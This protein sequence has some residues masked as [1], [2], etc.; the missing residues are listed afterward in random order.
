M[1]PHRGVLILVFGILSLVVCQVFGIAAWVMGNTDLQEMDWGRMDPTGR[2]L[3]KAGRICGM[4]GT[5]IL[6]LQAVVMSLFGLAMLLAP[7]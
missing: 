4:V 1:K 3:T 7:R 2:D 5:G 6:I